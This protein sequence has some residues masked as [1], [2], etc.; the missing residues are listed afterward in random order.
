MAMAGYSLTVVRPTRIGR[1]T[2]P[3]DGDLRGAQATEAQLTARMNEPGANQMIGYRFNAMQN[4]MK[5]EE[6]YDLAVG[7]HSE[8]LN[9]MREEDRRRHVEDLNAQRKHA[10]LTSVINN[11][12]GAAMVNDP[13]VQGLLTPEV[14]S[15]YQTIAE[16]RIKPQVVASGGGGGRSA[17]APAKSSGGSGYDYKLA[18]LHMRADGLLLR[19]INAVRSNAAKEAQRI[20]S[21]VFNLEE[22]KRQL[23]ALQES[24]DSAINTLQARRVPVIVPNNRPATIPG[25]APSMP[26]QANPPPAAQSTTQLPPT[27]VKVLREGVTTEFANGQKWTLKNG[28]PTPVQ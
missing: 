9:Q 6:D 2:A 24:T 8:A 22:Q 7:Q 16:Q 17:S 3:S 20:S 15:M 12:G 27:A 19:E 4:R 18:G 26:P 28:K 10:T 23:K 11:P 5:A 21:T 14:R 25:P 1:L 13:N